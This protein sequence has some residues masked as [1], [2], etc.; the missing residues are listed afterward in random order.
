MRPRT[1]SVRPSGSA[2]STA[3]IDSSMNPNPSSA[4]IGAVPWVMRWAESTTRVC[5]E[6]GEDATP[7]TGPEDPAA[8]EPAGL[9]LIAV[10]AADLL[11][12]GVVG[13]RPRLARSSLGDRPFEHAEEEVL[14]RRVHEAALVERG[15]HEGVL[16]VLH[17]RRP[18]KVFDEVPVRAVGPALEAR[19]AT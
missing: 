15:D 8:H 16:G 5:V 13:W 7:I 10:R 1:R 17:R 12:Q 18:E 9:V 14:Q 19:R 2:I 4:N 3:S 11:Q 6:V